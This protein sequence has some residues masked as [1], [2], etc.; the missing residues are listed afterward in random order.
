MAKINKN[1]ITA[2]QS[3][4]GFTATARATFDGNAE[5]GWLCEVLSHSTQGDVRQSSDPFAELEDMLDCELI[6]LRKN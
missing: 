5:G 1:V 4:D 2:T 3:R 6:A